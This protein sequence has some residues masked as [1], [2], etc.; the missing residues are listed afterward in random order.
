MQKKLSVAHRRKFRAHIRR[1]YRTHGR[2]HLPW[3]GTRDPYAILV[4]EIMLQQ[5][6]VS[7]CIE[8][9]RE[10][11]STFPTT[12]EL[13]DAPL[14]SVLRAW[15]GLGYN[16]RARLLHQAAR[17]L[18]ASH[19]GA[20]PA[21]AATLETLPGIGPYTARAVM[22]FAHDAPEVMIETNI[23]SVFLHYFFANTGEV[24]DRDIIPLITDTLDRRNPREWY[25]A[26]MDYGSYV[27]RAQGNPNRRSTHHTRQAAFK[28]SS[29][30]VRGAL[31]RALSR[32]AASYT[33]LCAELP[34]DAARIDEALVGLERD[35]IVARARTRWR[36]AD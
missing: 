11:L 31:V 36:L 4:S 10:F 27:K 7:R 15:S 14:S 35:G 20:V 2:H 1:F 24:S 22:V 17:H 16:R 12:H 6:Q 30:E 8:K 19:G 18:V 32:R 33:T 29:R 3:R 5:T 23:R 9:Y 28:G 25:A 26:L 13:A 21:D 34:F